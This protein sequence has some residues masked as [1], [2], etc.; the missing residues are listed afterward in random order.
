MNK[1]IKLL[2]IGLLS[3]INMPNLK[4]AQY[5]E[6]LADL[7][8]YINPNNCIAEYF[9]CKETSKT[10]TN[11][12]NFAGCAHMNSL[13]ALLQV[14]VVQDTILVANLK[15]NNTVNNL[16]TTYGKQNLLKTIGQYDIENITML[17][18]D[19]IAQLNGSDLTTLTN[20]GE[21]P[22]PPAF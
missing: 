15:L 13:Q 17:L 10:G 9:A 21:K 18:N 4:A 22:V 2:M 1:N 14:P 11:C 3:I 8:F 12:L 7:E 5:V 6:N 19:L 20:A 16:L